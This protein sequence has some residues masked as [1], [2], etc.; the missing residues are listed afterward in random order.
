MRERRGGWASLCYDFAP[1]CVSVNA[2][3]EPILI[4]ASASPRRRDLLGLGGWEF[5][6]RPSEVNEARLADEEPES[7]ALRLAEA[8]ARADRAPAGGFT[9]AADTLVVFDGQVLGKP[10]DRDEAR[11]MLTDL[12]GRAHLVVTGLVLADSLGETQARACCITDVTMRNYTDDQMQ[13]YLDSGGPMDKAGAYG[14]QDREFRPVAIEQMSGCFANVMGLPLCH[15]AR[16][17]QA[18]GRPARHD[19]PQ[20]CFRHTGYAC[21]V[22]PQILGRES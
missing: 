7:M 17:L 11:H 3:D 9:L 4:L 10:R 5:A 6:L 21:T 8:K 13:A 19:V 2:V 22:F 18:L 16:A 20:A 15:A 14:I 12:R 1:V